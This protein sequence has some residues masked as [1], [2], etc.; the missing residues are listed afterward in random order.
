MQ[1]LTECTATIG[2]P[3]SPSKEAY[4]GQI[5]VK[6]RSVLGVDQTDNIRDWFP[7]AMLI[8]PNGYI[9]LEGEIGDNHQPQPTKPV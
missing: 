5:T 1:D 7:L 9:V 2:N 6:F 8:K 3:L 4:Q